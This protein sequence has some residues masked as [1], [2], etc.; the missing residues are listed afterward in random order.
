MFVVFCCGWFFFSENVYK[1]IQVINCFSLFFVNCM[2]WTHCIL[3][4]F[5]F[6]WVCKIKTIKMLKIDWYSSNIPTII[7]TTQTS[8]KN[9]NKTLQE[10]HDY[11]VY[12]RKFE[13]L[14]KLWY[15]MKAVKYILLNY[16]CDK[17]ATYQVIST[18]THDHTF[19][20]KMIF[21]YW[22]LV[23]YHTDPYFWWL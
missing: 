4:H 11:A 9:S 20:N 16:Q 8:K 12:G 2:S 6:I 15:C 3:C 23:N 19:T 22:Q 18:Q 17:S 1:F 21:K 5:V 10:T 7:I 13:M 14:I